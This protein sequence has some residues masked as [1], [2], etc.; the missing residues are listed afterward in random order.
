[1]KLVAWRPK[2]SSMGAVMAPPGR[3]TPDAHRRLLEARVQ[4]MVDQEPNPK[5]AL[6]R[7]L[8]L[9]EPLGLLAVAPDPGR[10]AGAQLVEAAA[11]LLRDKGALLDKPVLVPAKDSPGIR[12]MLEES[13]LTE[14]ASELEIGLV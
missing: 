14:W 4:A 10:W 1:M 3:L 9:W 5:A 2:G 13:Q 8:E 12:E 7:V 6:N 11:R